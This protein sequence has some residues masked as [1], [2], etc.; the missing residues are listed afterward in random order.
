MTFSLN[1]CEQAFTKSLRKFKEMEYFSD[2]NNYL[3]STVT[4]YIDDS[5]VNLFFF[6]K[7]FN[8][9]YRLPENFSNAKFRNKTIEIWQDEK[10]KNNFKS[11][12]KHTY[13]YNSSSR[14]IYYSYS[15]CMECSDMSY[16]YFVNYDTLNRVESIVDSIKSNGY[17][18]IYYDTSNMIK[19]IDCFGSFLSSKEVKLTTKI[20]RV[21]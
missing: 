8:V 17:Y 13:T 18:K 16:S 19:Q 7:H 10:D 14:L 21:Q 11:N 5:D 3:K 6:Y 20:L 15:S 12:S 9:P 1:S 2:G 4:L